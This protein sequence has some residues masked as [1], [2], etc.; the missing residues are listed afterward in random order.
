PVTGRVR[1]L[2]REDADMPARVMVT[3]DE[4]LE[5]TRLEKWYVTVGDRDRAVGVVDRF[6]AALHRVTGALLL[7]LD[8]GRDI[9][10]DIGDVRLDLLALVP[11][12]RDESVRG[13]AARGGERVTDQCAPTDL[14][15]QLAGSRLHPRARA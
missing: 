3:V 4:R 7:V 6:E 5:R 10:G 12:D 13:D 15:Q 9:R 11:G 2:G 14:V 1:G 8:G